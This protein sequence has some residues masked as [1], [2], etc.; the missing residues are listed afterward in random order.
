[1]PQT[2]DTFQFVADRGDAR[3]RLDRI[4]VRRLTD[5]SRLSRTLAQ[6]WIASGA[7]AVDGRAVH[8]PSVRVREGASVLVRLPGSTVRRSRPEAEPVP[9]SVLYEDAWI[10]AVDKPPGMVVH[11]T[12]TQLTGTVLNGILWRVRGRSDAQP[13]IVTRL[14][15]ETSG[16]VLVALTPAVHA[17][18]QRGA[19]TIRKE[20][21]AVVRGIPRPAQGLIQHPL[22]RDPFDRRRMT[23]AARGAASTTRYEVLS[24][25]ATRDGPETLVR[26][27]LLTG[28]TH[29]IRVHLAACGWP[30]VGDRT[31][32]REDP[33]IARQALHA[34]RLTFP[35][36][37]TGGRIDIEAPVPPDMHALVA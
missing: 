20:Y 8:R 21:L 3:L 6:Q 5:V 35:H 2:S 19:R 32:G 9:L 27:E 25:V 1:M 18:L 28:R 4:L 33:R 14:D 12:Y 24:T 17:A 26:C 34:R 11:P 37:Q 30:L 10:V 7:V 31:Y 16:L 23:V 29:Q 36:P 22:V 15:R 13:G